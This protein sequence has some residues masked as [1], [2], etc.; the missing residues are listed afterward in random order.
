WGGTKARVKGDKEHDYWYGE[1]TLPSDRD[2]ATISWG[3]EWRMPTKGELETLLEKCGEGVWVKDY[4]GSGIKGR[5]F[6]GVGDGFTE[7]ELFF[8]A[9][10]YC[11]NGDFYNVGAGGDCWSG[12][13]DSGY[14]AWY[15]YF[16]SGYAYLNGSYR[17]NGQSVRAVCAKN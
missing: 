1:G 14:D 13:P 10:G 6:R 3:K 11:Y 7:Q 16:N 15:L 9:A 12:V 4:K 8:P 2:I 17:C 5:L